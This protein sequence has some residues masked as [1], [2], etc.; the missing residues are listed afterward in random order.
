[1]PG[2]TFT[3]SVVS[4]DTVGS[5]S[6][7]VTSYPAT[8]KLDVPDPSIYSNMGAQAVII[9]RSKTDTLMV[10]S[11]SIQT[12]D[13]SSF[14]RILTKNRQVDR[15][16]VETGISSD[17]QTEILSGLSEGDVVVTSTTNGTTTQKTNG[18][19]GSIFGGG[20]FRMGR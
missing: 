5:V 3:G 20:G 13:G 16:A 7:G 19:T 15:N 4:I 14:V 6:S 9:T 17:T 1:L 8:I 12:M 18:Q 10:P 11:S 2:K